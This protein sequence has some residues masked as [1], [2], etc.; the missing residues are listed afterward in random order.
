MRYN[1]NS[2][3]G[4]SLAASLPLG[5]SGK[6]LVVGD[7]STANRDM[8]VEL[9]GYDPDGKLRF[10]STVQAA[11]TAC[12]SNAG[13]IILVAPGHSEAVTASSLDLSVAGITVVNMG[14]ADNAPTYTYGAAAATID[15][16]AANVT[17]IGGNLT[18]NFLDVASAFTLGAAKGFTVKDA[19][20]EDTS[21]ILNF[22][23][24]VTT[25]ATDNDADDLSVLN[26]TVYGLNTTPL[27]L[28]SILAAELRPT[29]SGNYAS[30]AATSGG[31]FITLAAKVVSGA[32]FKDNVHNIVG[33]TDTTTG[34]FLTGS[35]TSTGIVSGNYVA[36]LD[37][38]S[39][40]I[41]TAGTGLVFFENYYT[42][43]AD[44]SGKLWPVVDAA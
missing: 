31:E 7:S 4:Q 19:K 13:D 27:A 6:V 38:T 14:N 9:F 5:L 30:L 29:V 8:L 28:V 40:L 21:S 32:Q 15:V 25:G 37:T 26:N 3:W 2:G 10:Y 42:G 1:L 33:A 24:I 44:K 34:I 11:V 36:S 22:L 23:S 41:A 39:E 43:V 20:F 17:W 18:A 16:S 12:T 35:G